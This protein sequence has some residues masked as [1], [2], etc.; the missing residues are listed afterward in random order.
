VAIPV[1]GTI[2]AL[3]VVLLAHE[4]REAKPA[5]DFPIRPPAL[6]DDASDAPVPDASPTPEGAT[7]DDASGPEEKSAPKPTPPEPPPP[8]PSQYNLRL[9]KDGS[10]VDLDSSRS[11]ADG[12]AVAAELADEKVRHRIFLSNGEGVEEAALD[13]LLE[14]LSAKF[15]MRKVYRAPKKKEE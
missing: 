5:T 15:E 1:A 6:E 9:E 12:A 3:I 7:A 2:A 14:E 4:P 13:K 10:L 11:F 8:P